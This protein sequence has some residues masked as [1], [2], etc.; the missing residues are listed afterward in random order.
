M[1]VLDDL[2]AHR[3]PCPACGRTHALALAECR[4]DDNGLPALPALYARHLGRPAAVVVADARTR[5]AAGDRVVA[6]LAGAGVRASL[7]LLPDPAPGASPCCDE[8]TRAWLEERLPPAAAPVAVG[9][10]VINDLVKWIAADRGVPYLAVATAAS[11][12]GYASDN[13]APTIDGV[14]SLVP[15]RGPRAVLT[16]LELLC[17]APA[18]LT[19][20]G[21]GDVLAKPVSAADWR[22]GQLLFGDFYCARCVELVQAVEPLYLERAEALAAGAPEALAALFEALLLSGLAMSMAGTSSPASGGE[23]LISHTLDMLAMRDGLPHDLH[24]RQVG[25]GTVLAAALYA[26]LLALERFPPAPAP[27]PDQPDPRFWGCLTPAVA[28]PLARK[29]ARVRDAGARLAAAPALWDDVR[30]AL[31]P[32]LRTPQQVKDTLRRAGAAHTLAQIGQ[33]PARFLPALLHAHQIRDRVTVLDLAWL[34]G[35]L[36]A[37]A[38]T[39]VTQW[40]DTSPPGTPG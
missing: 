33:T 39:L 24:G 15:A 25:V 5:I 17:G 32:L 18:A 30:N 22:L 36:P 14:K 10:G 3:G 35:L 4:I 20:A 1:R 11:M 7:L 27:W 29:A 26:E 9:S 16:S 37:R 34:A 2:L 38:E 19:A 8:P 21:L 31:R 23:H 40:L 12:N 6:R 13:V 28:G